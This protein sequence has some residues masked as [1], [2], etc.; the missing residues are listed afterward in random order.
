MK[1]NKRNVYY[2]NNILQSDGLYYVTL[3]PIHCYVFF[4]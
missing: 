4:K 1:N 3:K 2:M